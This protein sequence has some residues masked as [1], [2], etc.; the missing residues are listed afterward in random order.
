MAHW[1]YIATIECEGLGCIL[2]FTYSLHL[3][4][5]EPEGYIVVMAPVDNKGQRSPQWYYLK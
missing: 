4:L 2:S 3:L 5:F 1:E